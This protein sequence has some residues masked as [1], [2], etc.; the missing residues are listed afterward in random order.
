MVGAGPIGLSV[1]EF[2]KLGG[3]T[4][5]GHG[6]ESRR[7]EFVQ[8]VMGCRD[9]LLVRGTDRVTALSEA[10]EVNWRSILVVDATGSIGR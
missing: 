1:I 7:L 9:T 6:H 4:D 8:D 10:T 5:A 2:A 3:G